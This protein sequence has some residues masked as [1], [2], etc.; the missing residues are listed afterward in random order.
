MTP[1]NT[2]T[3]AIQSASAKA[4]ETLENILDP[5]KKGTKKERDAKQIGPAH[6]QF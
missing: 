6:P 2:Y 3:H 5:L 4:A 1:A